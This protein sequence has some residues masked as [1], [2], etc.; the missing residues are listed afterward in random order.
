MPS[1]RR[2]GLDGRRYFP[3]LCIAPGDRPRSIADLDSDLAGA[4]SDG[5]A[6]RGGSIGAS[7]DGGAAGWS[8]SHSDGASDSPEREVKVSPELSWSA[9]TEAN[10]STVQGSTP[11][12]SESTVRLSGSFAIGVGVP[13][14]GAGGAKAVVVGGG[15]GAASGGAGA[16]ANAEGGAGACGSSAADAT[17]SA[18][19]AALL[20]DGSGSAADEGA[21]Q[22]AEAGAGVQT[23]VGARPM[24]RGAAAGCDPRGSGA[25]DGAAAAT[26]ARPGRPGQGSPA[27]TTPGGPSETGTRAASSASGDSTASPVM[28]AGTLYGVPSL[29]GSSYVL[30]NPQDLIIGPA[31]GSPT[32]P[33]PQNLPVRRTSGP[34]TPGSPPPCD[35]EPKAGPPL[36]PVSPELPPRGRAVDRRLSLPVT[37][38]ATDA[39]LWVGSDPNA[40]AVGSSS[41]LNGLERLLQSTEVQETPPVAVAELQLYPSNSSKPAAATPARRYARFIRMC[42]CSFRVGECTRARLSHLLYVTESALWRRLDPGAPHFETHGSS[43]TRAGERH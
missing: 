14:A 16:G 28:A 4:S 7:L 3:P 21:R 37:R 30:P 15:G 41:P 12:S 22:G 1:N 34:G 29:V 42:R 36:V 23:G 40:A 11:G 18:S 35:P 39:D 38:A 24:M 5:L 9:G 31:A 32:Y 33:R 17:Q 27:E 6:E 19:G 10:L 8:W 20:V 25:R 2:A 13:G 26:P 43:F